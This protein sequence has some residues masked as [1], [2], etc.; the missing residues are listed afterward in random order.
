MTSASS[1]PLAPS[2]RF[3]IVICAG[4]AQFA[5]LQRLLPIVA[6][7][8]T[9]H[10]ASS[11]LEPEQIA[12]L[13]PWVDV[14]HEPKHDADGYKNFR[15]FC[16]RDINRVVSAPYFIKLDTDVVL[17]ADWIKYVED[18]LRHD[19]DA[20]L[21][22]PN[23]GSNKINYDISGSLVRRRLGCDLKVLDE[24]KV[25]GS[26]Y[27]GSTAFFRKHDHEMQVLHDL[28]YAFKDGRRFRPNHMGEDQ[29]EVALIGDEIDGEGEVNLEP[30]VVMR[31]VCALRAGKASEDNLRSLAVHAVG[32][33][34]RLVV[35]GARERVRVADKQR[36]PRGLMWLAKR[37][38]KWDQSRRE[39][40][41]RSSK[42]PAG[43]E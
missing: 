26:F 33:S 36:G 15:L 40:S 10:L 29:A 20:V 24:L 14:L 4:A 30:P 42:K 8:G 5:D 6:P 13:S 2:S 35:R 11:Y 31:G 7:C 22:G 39:V 43:Y 38:K 16:I 21:L 3:D 19:P 27:V 9:V 12:A 25:D 32:A 34:A 37:L 23:E 1:N 41:W 17:S 28:I 18:C